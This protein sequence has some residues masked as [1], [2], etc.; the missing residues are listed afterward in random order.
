MTLKNVTLDELENNPDLLL[1]TR[2]VMNLLGVSSPTLY[3]W[4]KIN[5]IPCYKVCG[6]CKYRA[7]KIVE[8]LKENEL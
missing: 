1:T 7:D 4:R 8:F 6:L 2:Q 5:L 3:R